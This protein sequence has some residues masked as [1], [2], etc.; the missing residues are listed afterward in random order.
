[1]HKITLTSLFGCRL[2]DG[3]NGSAGDTEGG[4]DAEEEVERTTIWML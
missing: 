2:A 1:M 3:V 4:G